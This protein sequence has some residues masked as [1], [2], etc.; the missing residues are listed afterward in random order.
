MINSAESFM[1]KKLDERKLNAAFRSLKVGG[2]QVDFFSNDYLGIASKEFAFDTKAT[3]SSQHNGST[4]SRLLA[5]HSTEAE[6]LEDWIRNEFNAEAA[7]VFNSGFDANLGLMSTLPGRN[8]TVFYDSLVHASLREGIRLSPCK[9]YSFQHNDADD[10]RKKA[11][12]SQGIVYVVI[13]SVYSM[14]GDEPNLADFVR[15]CKEFGWHLIVD[16]AHGLGVR[17]ESGK[18]SSFQ[19]GSSEDI[20]A[21]V[22]TFGKAAGFHGAA[23]LGSKVLIDFLVNFCRPFIYST[24]LPPTDYKKLQQLLTYLIAAEEERKQLNL[25]VEQFR[26]WQLTQTNFNFISSLSPIQNLLVPG[27]AEVSKLAEYLQLNGYDVRPIKNPTV[28]VGSERLRII[29]H[30]YNTTAELEGLIRL[31]ADFEAED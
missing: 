18:G 1:R 17:G 22:L 31:L 24:A 26:K 12:L 4:G 6:E 19:F 29:L 23:V 15:V 14:D 5:G 13:E 3:N 21:R 7:L 2:N 30:S 28:P 10:L 27:N 8:D 16:E 9:A 20:F 25:L 11:A